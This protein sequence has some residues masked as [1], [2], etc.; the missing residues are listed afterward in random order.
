MREQL[1]MEMVRDAAG[2]LAGVA[3]RT[4]LDYSSTFSDITG[5]H[6]YLKLENLQKTGSFKIRGAY[7]AIAGLTGTE[8]QRGVIAAS[9][10]NH[11]QG[12]AYAA[13]RLGIKST[14]VMPRS[15]PIA[16]ITATSG[17]GADVIPAGD[18][19][20]EAYQH[21]MELQR[22]SGATYIHSFDDYRIIAGQGTLAL[23]LLEQLSDP[24][25]VVVPIGG[26]GLISGVAFV[27][28]QLKPGIK[29]VGVQAEGAP[30]MLES[31]RL[32]KL[33]MIS[34]ACT[35]ADGIAVGK[36]GNATFEIIC[37]YV[38]EM[39]TVD[40]EEISRALLFLLERSKLV[41][42]GAG[43]VGIA[44]L[45]QHKIICPG[46]KVAVIISGG[47]IDSNTMSVI[48]ERGL[49][50]DGR[51]LRISC[52]L[53]DT[54][55]SL[56]KL[57]VEIYRCNANVISI[58]HDRVYPGVPLRNARVEMVLETR[59]REHISAIK[60]CLEERGYPAKEY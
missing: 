36:P 14:I 41:V 2:L 6:V 40:D 19:Y 43:A 29:V 49:I 17:Y 58:T 1:T 13:S 10:G 44:A 23:E 42:E 30:A 34:S 57:L 11:A 39:V 22:E 35:I 37:Q 53:P 3:H 59:D 47:N 12:V 54:P 51:R 50:K 15:A 52:L 5:N 21:A 9:A 18:N 56:Q 28:K 45:L 16:K 27:L 20:D 48:I 24:D 26:G 33:T 31:K 8:K 4:P 55:G 32:G 7:Y 60:K 46:Q 38:D 25:V